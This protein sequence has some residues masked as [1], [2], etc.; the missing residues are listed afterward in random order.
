[1]FKGILHVY[2]QKSKIFLFQ[3]EG[4]EGVVNLVMSFTPVDTPVQL[5]SIDQQQQAQIQQQIYE[6]SVMRECSCSFYLDFV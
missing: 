3:G 6:S 1:M 5:P 4:K 2:I